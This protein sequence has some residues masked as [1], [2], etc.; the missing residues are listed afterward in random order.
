MAA[1]EVISMTPEPVSPLG[2]VK[3]GKLGAAATRRDDQRQQRR[4][5]PLG[6]GAHL[7]SARHRPQGA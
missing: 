6:S 3:A 7:H 2:P 1:S 4:A 5:T